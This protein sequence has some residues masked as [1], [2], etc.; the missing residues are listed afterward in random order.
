MDPVSLRRSCVQAH[1]R[2]WGEWVVDRA[3]VALAGRHLLCSSATNQLDKLPLR[4]LGLLLSMPS[5]LLAPGVSPQCPSR[6]TQYHPVSV[7]HCPSEGP[8]VPGPLLCLHSHH[9][10]G[11]PCS[12]PPS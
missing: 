4:P 12:L 8:G 5:S 2:R 9:C 1:T 3:A 11:P 10:R 7:I 6:L